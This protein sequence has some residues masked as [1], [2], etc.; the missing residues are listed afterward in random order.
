MAVVM[1]G[2]RPRLMLQNT[3]IPH[4]LLRGRGADSHVPLVFV[5]EAGGGLAEVV[6]CAFGHVSRTK[7]VVRHTIPVPVADGLLP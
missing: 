1:E 5:T 6:R 2:A 7:A 4:L 3:D